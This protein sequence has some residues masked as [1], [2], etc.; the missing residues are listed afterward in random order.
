MAIG[1]RYQ[2][3]NYKKQRCLPWHGAEAKRAPSTTSSS[4]L[5]MVRLLSTVAMLRAALRQT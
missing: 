1:C 2:T 4:V 3:A 5:H